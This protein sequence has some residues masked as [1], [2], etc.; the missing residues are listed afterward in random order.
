MLTQYIHKILKRFFGRSPL[1]FRVVNWICNI[2]LF[3]SLVQELFLMFE[4]SFPYPYDFFINKTFII[5][6]GITRI[7]SGL[8]VDKKHSNETEETR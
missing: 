4:I 3:I 2:C 5:S 1:F 8:T 7:L 6:A